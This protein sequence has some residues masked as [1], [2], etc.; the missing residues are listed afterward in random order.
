MIISTNHKSKKQ[1]AIEIGGDLIILQIIDNHQ[2]WRTFI[3]PNGQRL[4]PNATIDHTLVV[5][6]DDVDL[7]HLLQYIYNPLTADRLLSLLAYI[8]INLRY[9]DILLL[10]ILYRQL[11]YVWQWNR[12][13]LTYSPEVSDQ[14]TL[15]RSTLRALPDTIITPS[16]HESWRLLVEEYNYDRDITDIFRLQMTNGHVILVPTVVD[17]EFQTT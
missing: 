16:N 10:P 4:F 12:V 17:V 7:D 11:W 5:S 9:G 13:N 15:I 2:L 3:I 1:M 14:Q 8:D 6:T